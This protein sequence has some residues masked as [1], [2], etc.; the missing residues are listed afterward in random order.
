[1][2]QAE[3]HIDWRGTER[4]VTL[5]LWPQAVATRRIRYSLK[6]VSSECLI[7]LSTHG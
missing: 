1:M 2:K 3:R 7:E 5:E 4:D 6:D